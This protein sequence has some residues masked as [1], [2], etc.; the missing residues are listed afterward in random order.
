MQIVDWKC[1]DTGSIFEHKIDFDRHCKRIHAEQ[2][3]QEKY[4][5]F[6][7]NFE[8]T[9]DDLRN[10]ATS[11]TEI[12][13]WIVANS[14]MLYQHH[15]KI[16]GYKISKNDKF[17]ITNVTIDGDWRHHISNTHV[18]PLNGGVTNWYRKSNLPNGYSGL[19]CRMTIDYDSDYHGFM[20]DVFRGTGIMFGGT[21][22]GGSGSYTATVYFFDDDWHGLKTMRILSS[23]E[24]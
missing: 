11:T 15:C 17:K 13:E 8:K 23:R 21:D 6:V 18:C 4:E 1:T 10:S 16:H 7:N 12:E 24:G 5:Q 2:K 3:K 20:S 14:D 22:G 9:L 19:Q